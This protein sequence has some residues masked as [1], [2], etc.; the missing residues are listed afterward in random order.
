MAESIRLEGVA[1]V[2]AMIADLGP[3]LDRANKNAQ[4]KMA[5]ELMVAE[6]DQAKTRFDRPTPYTVSSI[7]YKKTDATSFSVSGGGQSAT[8]N[9]PDIKGAGVFVVDIAKQ[10]GADADAYLGVQTVGG[11]TAKPRRSE[12]FLQKEGMMPQGYVWVPASG[13]SFNTY[14]IIPAS[15][16]WSMMRDLDNN[17]GK[18]KTYFLMGRG[19]GAMGV[20]VK[21]M[22]QWMPFLWFIKPRDYQPR[23]GFY[24]RADAEIAAQFNKILSDAI[25]YQLERMAR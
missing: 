6:K 9:T 7:A 8:V 11:P 1:S 20:Y 4:N 23:L 17:D 13:A 21:K 25:D 5:Y 16:I 22:G 14:G 24:E 18:G 15:T 2:R 10:A 3:G 12:V 19:D